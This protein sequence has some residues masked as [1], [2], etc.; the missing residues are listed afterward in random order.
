MPSKIEELADE[1]PTSINP[2]EVLSLSKDATAEEIKAAYRKAALKHH[3][4]K[5]KPEDKDSAH[6][7]FQEIAFAY[8]VLSDERRRKRYDTTGRTEETLDLEDDDFDWTSFY[9][10]Q[11][12]DVV[13]GEKLEAFKQEFK[14]S[15]E[16][17]QAVLAAYKKGKGDLDVVY[18]E[19]MLSNPLNDEER[20]RNIIDEAVKAGEVE[21]YNKYAKEGKG[22]KDKRMKEAKKEEKEARELAEELGVG[23][24]LFG[25]EGNDN[26]KGRKGKGKGKKGAEK[27][28]HDALA[29]LIQNRQ[30]D[31][32]GFF[33]A[34]EAKYAPKSKGTSKTGPKGRKRG[35][36][37]VDDEDEDE[38]APEA[39]DEPPEEAFRAMGE[40]KRHAKVDSS[41]DEQEA[42]PVP[43]KGRGRPKK[44][45]T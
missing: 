14:G 15:E 5:A 19:V 10:E 8:A 6:K 9:R 26:A 20:F 27:E 33:D 2:Y 21:H 45:K 41:D 13:T 39:M 17:R 25:K 35:R 36:V 23:E 12:R 30:K 38:D 34:L 40:R 42:K 43:K 28:S 24:K 7:A 3:P 32:A 37:E 1:A 29:A 18:E 11:Y 31:R 22:K 4:D 44:V 16:E